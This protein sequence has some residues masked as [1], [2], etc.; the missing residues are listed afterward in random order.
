MAEL[1]QQTRLEPVTL[2]GH[3][4]RLEPL[5][6]GERSVVAVAGAGEHRVIGHDPILLCPPVRVA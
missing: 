1:T 2:A 5:A 4:I 6:E 3:G